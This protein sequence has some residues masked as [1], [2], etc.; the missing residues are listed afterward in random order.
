MKL[1]R[2]FTGSR[3]CVGD[4]SLHKE[5]QMQLIRQA[6]EAND[7][8]EPECYREIL[9]SLLTASDGKRILSQ[10]DVAR[11]LS[12]SRGWVINRLKV[13][14]GGIAVE[15]LAMKLAKEFC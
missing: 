13:G 5:H 3:Q 7:T 6:R 15:A 10:T 4:V 14:G 12:K 9:E 2:S 11:L 8:R 1:S